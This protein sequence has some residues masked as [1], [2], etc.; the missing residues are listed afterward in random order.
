[1]RLYGIFDQNKNYKLLRYSTD[2]QIDSVYQAF[3]YNTKTHYEVREVCLPNIEYS[4]SYIGK[5]YNS[6]TDTFSDDPLS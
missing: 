5:Y 3:D 2:E 6:N 4:D 1:M